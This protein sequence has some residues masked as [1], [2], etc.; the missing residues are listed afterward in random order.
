MDT[1]VLKK[2]VQGLNAIKGVLDKAIKFVSVKM[3]D[4]EK[5]FIGAMRYVQ[6][7]RTVKW[8]KIPK[9]IKAAFFDASRPVV[10]EALKKVKEAGLAVT[11][12]FEELSYD[13]M[14][15]ALTAAVDGF[16]GTNEELKEKLGDTVI[17]LFMDITQ[18]L[19]VVGVVG[20]KDEPPKA[21]E[22]SKGSEVGKETP[23]ASGK[24]TTKEGKSY[25]EKYT[26]SHAL[27]DALRAEAR[28]GATK[29]RIIEKAQE[30]WLEK[31]KGS[32]KIE[33]SRALFRYVFPSL[34]ILGVVSFENGKVL[35]K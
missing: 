7:R 22:G 35:L 2:A 27:C 34:V 31:G 23:V 29:E 18:P 15:T 20:E 32:D 14:I 16:P 24:K 5:Q 3:E 26:R 10:I 12:G 28:K 21:E 11:D 8:G 19:P 25:Q 33:V 6:V 17:D 4:V 30:L 9:A 13:E 1:K